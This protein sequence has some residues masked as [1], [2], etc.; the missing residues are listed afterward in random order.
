MRIENK[1]ELRLF[2]DT[3]EQCGHSILVLTPDGDQYDLKDPMEKY[4]G[5]ACLISDED[6]EIFASDR[7]DEMKLF[8]YLEKTA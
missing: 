7:E 5:I 4:A 3:L 2:E 6:S 8:R 1:D